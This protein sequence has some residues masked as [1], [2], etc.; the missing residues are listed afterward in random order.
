MVDAGSDTTLIDRYGR[1]VLNI[2]LLKEFQDVAKI[3]GLEENHVGNSSEKYKL[4][5]HPLNELPSPNG[6]GGF[7]SDVETILSSRT[8]AKSQVKVSLPEFL[9]ATEDDLFRMGIPFHHDRM[10][11]LKYTIHRYHLKPWKKSSMPAISMRN[12]K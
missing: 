2:A 10:K 12:K 1:T 3:L 6:T 8:L 4:N 11:L 5:D 9:N 7:S